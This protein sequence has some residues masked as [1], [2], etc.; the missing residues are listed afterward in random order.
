MVEATLSSMEVSI[1]GYLDE[2]TKLNTDL[3]PIKYNKIH[4]LIYYLCRRLRIRIPWDFLPILATQPNCHRWIEKHCKNI[5][6]TQFDITRY[7]WLPRGKLTLF[8]TVNINNILLAT[9]YNCFSHFFLYCSQKVVLNA[10][11][12]H[13]RC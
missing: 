5:K 7:S 9:F 10:V 11:H 3:K 4:I 2:T 12:S 8:V 6:W 1:F 13:S